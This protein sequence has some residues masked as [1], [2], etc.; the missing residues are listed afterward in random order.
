MAGR[1]MKFGEIRRCDLELL[2]GKKVSRLAAAYLA[3]EVPQ[4]NIRRAF[5]AVADS[6]EVN[7]TK[8]EE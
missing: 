7:Q 4:S 8:R 2:S 3:G 1:W 6:L 5:A